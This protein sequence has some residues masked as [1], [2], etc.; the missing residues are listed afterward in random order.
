MAANTNNGG[1]VPSD[2]DLSGISIQDVGVSKSVAVDNR[3]A[4]ISSPGLVMAE[5]SA[6]DKLMLKEAAILLE[7]KGDDKVMSIIENPA[8]V[9]E[10]KGDN[11]VMFI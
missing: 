9:L 8:I 3:H 1:T 2:V 5:M 7:R 10:K 6:S 11:K 4:N